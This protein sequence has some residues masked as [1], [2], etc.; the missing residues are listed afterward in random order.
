VPDTTDLKQLERKAWTSYHQ[1]GL[2]D[3]FLGLL[4][5]AGFFGDV[6]SLGRV[7]GPVL[8]L[9]CAFFLIAAKKWITV[10]RMGIV[11]FGPERRKKRKK[12]AFV[13]S[14]AVLITMGLLG[15]TMAGRVGWIRDNQTAF[16]FLLGAGVWLVFIVMAYMQDFNR[17]YAIGALFA[18]AIAARELL[19][20]R[21][22]LLIAGLVASAFGIV[23]L[24]HFL[25]KYP[26]P[27]G[28]LD[29]T[30]RSAHSR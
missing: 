20:N 23:L 30:N 10:P 7:A 3:L 4:L 9:S 1:D 29:E 2:V 15:L 6:G 17:L 28:E 11:K 12:T 5:I 27:I 18:G 13:A 16:S 26:L 14:V 25:R 21:I 22:F 8:Q 24:V 19:D